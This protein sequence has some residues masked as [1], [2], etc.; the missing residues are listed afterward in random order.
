[1][2]IFCSSVTSLKNSCG[3]LRRLDTHVLGVVSYELH[4]FAYL[5]TLLLVHV[6][7]CTCFNVGACYVAYRS[8][9]S[10][11]AC[12]LLT[13]YNHRTRM[14]IDIWVLLLLL[15]VLFLDYED[16]YLYC[17]STFIWC[18]CNWLVELSI[19]S[20]GLSFEWNTIFGINIIAY[21]TTYL[22]R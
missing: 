10:L 6:Y 9:C 2:R 12:C 18:F 8:C 14:V 21:V 20:C 3:V 15:T 13:R 1:M 22:N 17:W 5:T 11:V 16:V 19:C 7:F 4:F